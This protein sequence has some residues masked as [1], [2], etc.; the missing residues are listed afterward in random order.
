MAAKGIYINPT[1]FVPL[2]KVSEGLTTEL[3]TRQFAAGAYTGFFNYL[4]DP[5]P[6]LRR[7]GMDQSVYE[8]LLSDDQV[9]PLL[10]RRKNLTK[11]LDWDVEPNDAG[12]AEVELCK[13]TL[14]IL[15]ENGCATK[16]IISQTLNPVFY[17]YSTFEIIWGMVD[18]KYLP[19]EIWEKPREWFVF[20]SLN[21]LR[22]RTIDNYEGMIIRGKD[23]DPKI[24]AKFILLRNDPSF[25]NPYGDKALSRCFWP[26]TFK[27]GGMR[28]FT[29]FLEKYGMPFIFGKL[30]RGA[31]QED[32]NDLLSKLSNMVQDAVATGPDDSSIDLIEMKGSASGDLHEKYLQRC[33]NAI[34]K[35]LLLNAL[36][37]DIQRVGGRASA[38][39]GAVIIEG[40]IKGTDRD[41]PTTF[42]NILFK[43]V[44][45]LNIG[46]GKYPTLEVKEIEDI[47]KDLSERDVNLKGIG[48]NF[49]PDYFKRKYNLEDDEFDLSSQPALPADGLPPLNPQPDVNPLKEPVPPV[50]DALHPVPVEKTPNSFSSFKNL[51]N[52]FI[53]K[54]IELSDAAASNNSIADL[55]T[56]ALPDKLLQFSIEQTLKP[57]IE[58]AKKSSSYDGFKNN[59]AALFPKMDTNQIEDMMTKVLLIT[60]LEGNVKA[61]ADK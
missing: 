56:G 19:V 2:N 51:L 21:R 11:S 59:L 29:T 37:T 36:S 16:D 5:D 9:G 32:H 25:K 31:K 49:T 13:K 28:F 10:N 14:R 3:A 57:V 60:E 35:A 53:G 27:R 40:D 4:P 47:N 17:G 33:D 54:R 50:P 12:D 24:A 23:A 15:E 22:F 6:V 43:R 61:E 52:K 18:G 26:V 34:T 20:D 46:S 1:T 45:D 8:D 48:V 44:V 58:L 30:P 39:T 38:D 41:F 55:V 42:F 7:L